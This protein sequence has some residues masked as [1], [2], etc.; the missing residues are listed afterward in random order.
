MEFNLQK[1]LETIGGINENSPVRAP[2]SMEI[3]EK[4]NYSPE[5]RIVNATRV[6]KNRAE[7]K[8]NTINRSRS[9][10]QAERAVNDDNIHFI[11]P[12]NNNIITP[13]LRQYK[14]RLNDIYK[15]IGYR[16]CRGKEVNYQGIRLFWKGRML[17][18]TARQLLEAEGD[19]NRLQN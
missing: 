7:E 5:K 15:N 9:H 10:N 6:N 14:G 1:C 16:E 12:W 18:P 17:K 11:I 2:T 3:E 4:L 13:E 19:L 8:T